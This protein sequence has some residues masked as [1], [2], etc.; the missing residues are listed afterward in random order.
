MTVGIWDILHPVGLALFD[1]VIVAIANNR[2]RSSLNE[3]E[4]KDLIRQSINGNDNVI[5]DSFNGLL[6]QYVKDV[7]RPL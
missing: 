6:V 7:A 2:K 4:R 3:E 5:I 1:K